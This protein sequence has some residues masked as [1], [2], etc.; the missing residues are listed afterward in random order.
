MTQ[1]VKTR[2][3][4]SSKQGLSSGFRFLDSHPGVKPNETDTVA[5][6]E[7]EAL[8]VGR[9][10]RPSVDLC[11]SDDAKHEEAASPQQNA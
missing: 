8:Q 9:V 10:S 1:A 11:D 6:F 2:W 7:P 3:P 5:P 4:D